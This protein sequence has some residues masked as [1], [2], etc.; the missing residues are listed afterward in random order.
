MGDVNGGA[1]AD[2]GAVVAGKLDS[3]NGVC[4]ANMLGHV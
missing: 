1:E 4:V 2:D 3:G